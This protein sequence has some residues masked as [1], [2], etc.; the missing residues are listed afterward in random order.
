[1][2]L[3][4]RRGVIGR[5]VAG[6]LLWCRLRMIMSD[7]ISLTCNILTGE[8]C[9]PACIPDDHE[10]SG[11]GPQCWTVMMS[12]IVATGVS[13]GARTAMCHVPGGRSRAV[14]YTPSPTGGMGMAWS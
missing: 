7:H 12:S 6:L 4:A 9:V 10:Q 11:A 8:Q 5:V 1:M 13:A 14:L 3:G 2:W